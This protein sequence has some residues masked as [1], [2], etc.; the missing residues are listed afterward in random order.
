VGQL[1]DVFQMFRQEIIL[2]ECRK[3]IDAAG[4]GPAATLVLVTLL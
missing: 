2:L 4:C 1:N 3:S